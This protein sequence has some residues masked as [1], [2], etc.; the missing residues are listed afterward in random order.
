MVSRSPGSV[1]IAVARVNL[2][3]S[4]REYLNAVSD[5]LKELSKSSTT[6]V[7]IPTPVNPLKD[8]ITGRKRYSSYKNF[9]NVLLA[10]L[11]N[12]SRRFSRTLIVSPIIRRAGNRVYLMN[13]IVPPLGNPIFKGKTVTSFEGL[14]S[15]ANDIDLITIED[16]NMCFI[17]LNDLEVPEVFRVCKLKGGDA[18]VTI[19]PPAIT[20]RDPN[21]TLLIAAVRARENNIPVIG[22]GGYMSEGI[23]QPS[24]VINRDGSVADSSNELEPDIFEVEI[25]GSERRINIA[26]AR[27]YLRLIRELYP[28]QFA[29]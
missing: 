6:A 4:L 16:I 29:A 12:L 21:L 14:V 18:V 20:Y 15:G 24:F 28:E 1:T 22:A 11:G 25:K 26:L 3:T 19:Q 9:L 8:I 7:I 27:K 10:R 5:T 23:Q 13:A 2:G 17:I